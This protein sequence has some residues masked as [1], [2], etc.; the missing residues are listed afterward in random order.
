MTKG[1]REITIEQIEAVKKLMLAVFSDEPWNDVWSEEQ[2]HA[3][4]AQLMGER[5]SLSYGIYLHGRLIGVSLG[6][7]KSWCE[8]TEYWIEEFGILPQMQG[9]G[10]GSRFMQEIEKDLIKRGITHIVLLTGKS[11]PAYCFYQKNGFE[12]KK[13]YIFLAKSL[14]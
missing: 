1:I 5:H 11:V 2:L 6:K 14:N 7:V 8:G 10:I 12:E 3:Y 9:N 13:E 4:I